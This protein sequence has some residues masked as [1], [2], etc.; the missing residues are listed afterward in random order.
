MRDASLSILA[1]S[2]VVAEGGNNF[3]VPNGTFFF[4]LAIFLIVLAV[5]GTFVVPPVMRVL[6][7]RDNMVAKTAADNKKAAEQ[8]DAAKADYEE[9]LTE[10][11]VQA[12]S[13]RDNARAEGRKVVEDARASAEQ[14]VMST[15]QMASEQLKRERDAVELDLRANVAGMAATLASRILGVEVVPATSAASATGKSGR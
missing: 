2:Q 7:E 12:S 4:V 15:L 11:R 8:F 3:L 6:R 9:A 13:L 5:I 10:G 1:S 14:Q